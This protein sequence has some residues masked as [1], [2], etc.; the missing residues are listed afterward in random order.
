MIRKKLQ[1]SGISL[2]SPP[3]RAQRAR[4]RVREGEDASVNFPP[5]HS[6]PE[7]A[8]SSLQ[9]PPQQA[10]RARGRVRE[11]E[12]ASVNFPPQHSSPEP[13]ASS[14]QSPPQQAQRARGRVREGEDAS[15][16]F[17]P[18]PSSPEPAASSLQS[19]PQ[20]AQRARGRVREGEDA[21]VN[22]PPQHSSPEPAAPSLSSRR[23]FTLTELLVVITIIGMLAGMSLGALYAARETARVQKTKGTISKLDRIIQAKYAEF[24]TRRLPITSRRLPPRVMAELKLQVLR[25]IIRMEMPDRLNDIVY[26][27]WPSGDGQTLADIDAPFKVQAPQDPSPVV[28]ETLTRTAKARNIFRRVAGN[29]AFFAPGDPNYATAECL[30]LIVA[31]DPEAREQFQ[32]DEIGDVDGD[33]VPEFLDAWGMP[34]KFLRWAPALKSEMQTGNAPS[35]PATP[36]IVGD[37]E[38][39][40]DPFDPRRV[41]AYAFRLVP[42]IYSAGPDKKYGILSDD[43]DQTTGDGWSFQYGTRSTS[44]SRLYEGNPAKNIGRPFIDTDP[45]YATYHDTQLD[46]ITNHSLGMN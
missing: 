21:S 7:P 32:P 17:P 12:D 37:P 29:N 1:A 26:P 25:E 11:G 45:D 6:S 33:G 2:Q 28:E 14:L 38:N 40:H 9:S 22:F 24:K 27:R 35:P 3:Q 42:Y 46:N 5:Q 18:Q 39:D 43:I 44:V 13:A 19:P 4:G 31:S 16:N 41:D 23:G 34:I 10:Q 30:Y 20:R 8:A 36:P 15:V